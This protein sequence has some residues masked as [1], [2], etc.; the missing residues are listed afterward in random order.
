MLALPSKLL[1][2]CT[3]PFATLGTSYDPYV[4]SLHWCWMEAVDTLPAL[5]GTPPETVRRR[6]SFSRHTGL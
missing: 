5:A 1:R 6:S 2:A 3:S 4:C